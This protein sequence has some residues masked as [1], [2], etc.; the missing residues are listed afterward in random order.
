MANKV[1][2]KVFDWTDISINL[3]HGLAIFI[4]DISYKGSLEIE[5]V[6]GKGGKPQG[7]GRGN[8]KGE[9]SMTLIRE[10]YDKLVEWI[11]GQGSSI[12]QCDPFP[13]TVSYS[14]YDSELV[15][16]TLHDCKLKDDIEINPKQ[17]DKKIEVKLNFAIL[18]G[19]EYNGVPDYEEPR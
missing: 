10:E 5:E 11:S 1:N 4:T 13:I 3:P 7:W 17:G 19:I 9:G 18:K 14:D 16:D 2:G 12:L 15:T 6:Y 8:Y